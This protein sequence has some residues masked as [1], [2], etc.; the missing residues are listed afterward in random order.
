[1]CIRD[2]SSDEPGADSGADG[3]DT[4]VGALAKGI[5]SVDKEFGAFGEKAGPFFAHLRGGGKDAVATTSP[6]PPAQLT[7]PK[8]PA[9]AQSAAS[10]RGSGAAA[11]TR[12]QR[13]SASAGGSGSERPGSAPGS[14]GGARTH[15]SAK[16]SSAQGKSV[17]KKQAT[18]KQTTKKQTTTTAKPDHGSGEKAGSGT[19]GIVSS[20]DGAKPK[21]GSDSDGDNGED[22]A[23]AQVA[24]SQGMTAS[25]FWGGLILGV[26]LMAL[27]GGIV[28]FTAAA[29]MLRHAPK[30]GSSSAD[31]AESSGV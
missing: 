20:F 26:G 25:G 14:R 10:R 18:R 7:T 5:R 8:P 31:A 13:V 2:S 1:M 28:L 15:T 3:S 9:P 21:R 19:G 23:Q 24:T 6:K 17:P 22:A 4:W 30:P 12:E 11:P 27:L 29:K 16:T